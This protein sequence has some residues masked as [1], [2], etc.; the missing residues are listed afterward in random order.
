MR[1]A[2]SGR[3][4]WNE[5][6]F[7][8]RTAVARGSLLRSPRQRP[9][10]AEMPGRRERLHLGDDRHPHTAWEET[11]IL[12]NA[13]ARLSIGGIGDCERERGPFSALAS[14]ALIR[15][16]R[17]ARRHRRF[18][19]CTIHAAIIRTDLAELGLPNYWGYNT[20]GF[21]ALR[22]VL[23][24]MPAASGGIDRRVQDR[25]QAPCTKRP[26]RSCSDFRLQTT[27]GRGQPILGPSAVA[28]RH[29]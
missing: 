13:C 9:P 18:E 6:V 3:L 20:I 4:R 19:L 1:G 29:R 14:P 23:V 10:G 22:P 8:Y 24:F 25:G 15:L 21:F 27:S 12:R 2:L 16:P 28:A 26:S 11:I 17:Q 5:V 7:G